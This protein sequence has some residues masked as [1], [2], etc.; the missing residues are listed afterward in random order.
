MQ[1]VKAINQ[2]PKGDKEVLKQLEK[3]LKKLE[4]FMIFQYDFDHNTIKHI[5][6]IMTKED[7]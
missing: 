4:Q 1:K 3:R 7:V 2:Q 6:A 5:A